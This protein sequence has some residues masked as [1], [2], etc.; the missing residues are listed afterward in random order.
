MRS[1][2]HNP[3]RVKENLEGKINIGPTTYYYLLTSISVHLLENFCNIYRSQSTLTGIFEGFS[4]KI[5]RHKRK[6][7]TCK[8]NPEHKELS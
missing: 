1:N 5:Q 7:I 3:E 8:I 2:D 6:L 4:Q